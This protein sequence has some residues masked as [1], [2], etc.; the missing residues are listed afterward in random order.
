MDGGSINLCKHVIVETYF[1]EEQT[2]NRFCS[3]NYHQLFPYEI[4]LSSHLCSPLVLDIREKKV[5]HQQG[6]SVLILT[7][8]SFTLHQ[9]QLL[10]LIFVFVDY[11]ITF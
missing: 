10:N 11:F 9:A 1:G 6:N 7:H 4:G 3:N 5:L 2:Q 8:I